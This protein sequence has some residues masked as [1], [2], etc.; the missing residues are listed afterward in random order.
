MCFFFSL[1][2]WRECKAR[3][4]ERLK[5]YEV[6]KLHKRQNAFT[7]AVSISSLL[8]SLGI[9]ELKEIQ[10]WHNVIFL[11]ISYSN[12]GAVQSV[13]RTHSTFYCLYLIFDIS[14]L[15]LVYDTK[16]RFAFFYAIKMFETLMPFISIWFS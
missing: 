5:M 10:V 13:K 16:L 3:E 15:F 1:M 7:F 6:V 9:I 11:N 12:A 14:S 2:Q 8:L 4:R